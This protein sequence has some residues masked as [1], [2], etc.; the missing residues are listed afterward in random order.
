MTNC[1]LFLIAFG[2]IMQAAAV[3]PLGKELLTVIAATCASFACW[4]LLTS[5]GK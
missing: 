4:C 2:V 1:A 5:I 3:T